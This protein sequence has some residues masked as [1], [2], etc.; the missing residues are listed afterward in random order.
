MDSM[1][2]M[3]V[4]LQSHS[5]F[6][7]LLPPPADSLDPTGDMLKSEPAMR[8]HE[9]AFDFSSDRSDSTHYFHQERRHPSHPSRPRAAKQSRQRS[10]IADMPLCTAAPASAKSARRHSTSSIARKSYACAHSDCTHSFSR[11]ADLERH[12]DHVH[13]EDG[14]KKRFECDYAACPRNASPFHRKD[15]FRDHLRDQHKEDIPK[16]GS[17]A[18]QTVRRDPSGE[19]SSVVVAKTKTVKKD[20]SD[21]EL[22][23][24]AAARNGEQQ[25]KDGGIQPDWWRCSR[26]LKRVRVD[27]HSWTC[28]TCKG[29]IEQARHAFRTRF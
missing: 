12:I 3:D 10:C 5:D 6:N 19:R 29:N 1:D 22:L 7:Y 8:S 16:R 18:H 9:A 2:S 23:L 26:C 13:T 17:N 14:M 25:R 4:L 28:P 20:K 27:E 15:H 24:D 11:Q 21:D